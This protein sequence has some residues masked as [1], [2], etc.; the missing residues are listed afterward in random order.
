MR[1]IMT[2]AVAALCLAAGANSALAEGPPPSHDPAIITAPDWR[3]LP[4]SD[5]LMAVFPAN[6]HGGG[7]AVLKC[8]V[9]PDG[10]LRKCMVVSETPVG[11][12]FGAAAL[13]LT[14]Q[15]RFKPGTRDGVPISSWVELPIKWPDLPGATGGP[16]LLSRP[17]WL[18]A[19]ALADVRAAYPKGAKGSAT[20][21]LTCDLVKSGEPR[22]CSVQ[23]ADGDH[24]FREPA[25]RLSHSFRADMSGLTSRQMMSLLTQVLIHFDAADGA[26]GS[27]TSGARV[28][29]KANWVKLPGIGDFDA[30]YPAAA[31]AKGVMTGVGVV[32]CLVL[33][34]GSLG[35]CRLVSETPA[36]L[37]FGEAAMKLIETFQLDP[38]TEDGRPVDGARINIPLRLNYPKPEEK[39]PPPT[40]K[41]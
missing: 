14:P 16:L 30:L 23:K 17:H 12:G 41:S 3:K 21:L 36:G 4:S 5:D 7:R 19:P 31:K 13:A 10:L 18:A 9:A 6:A 8:E 20:V 38:W 25:I 37:G 32:N 22:N 35:D 34:G 11:Q 40:P 15:F 27:D 39:A 24:L 33:P 2:A 26:G 1:Q 28:V 29:A